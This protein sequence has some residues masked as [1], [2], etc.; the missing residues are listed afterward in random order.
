MTGKMLPKLA[1]QI[2][3]LLAPNEACGL[4]APPNAPEPQE[5]IAAPPPQAPLPP[6]SYPAYMESGQMVRL[7]TVTENPHPPPIAWRSRPNRT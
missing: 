7:P 5:V 2:V 3:A 4:A 6:G 1:L